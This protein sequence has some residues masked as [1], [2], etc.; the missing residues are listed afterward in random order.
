MDSKTPAR[1]LL[2]TG[3]RYIGLSCCLVSTLCLCGCHSAFVQATVHN[4]SG[5]AI[6]L[7]EVDYPSASFGSGQ[8]AADASFHYR[9]KISGDGPV[10]VS[11]TDSQEHEHK[12]K[13]PLLHEGE[14]GTL[15]LTLGPN[16]A[17]WTASIRPAH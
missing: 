11:W 9:F 5:K 12:A 16:A 8:L 2:T 10:Q 4:Q 14:E 1:T 3:L 17:Q 6:P 7:F 13:G 15:D